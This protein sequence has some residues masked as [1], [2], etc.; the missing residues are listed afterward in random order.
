MQKFCSLRLYVKTKNLSNIKK[1]Y[2]LILF[3]LPSIII[4]LLF[5][6]IPIYGVQIAF[7]DYSFAK[8][9][10]R[11]P[12]VGLRFFKIFFRSYYSG[13]IIKNT[14]ILSG[15]NLLF[16]FPFPI[17]LA[18]F[19]NRLNNQPIKRVI[20]TATYMP[21]FISIV[22]VVGMIRL[23]LSPSLGIYG[24]FMRFIGAEP[25]NLLAEPSLF[26]PIYVISEVWQHM[27]WNSI[28]FLAALSAVDV[29]LYESAQADGANKFQLLWYI[30]L[31]SLMPTVMI[32]LILNVGGLIGLG[33]DKVYLMQNNLNTS[34]SEV[35]STYIYKIGIQQSQYSF[36][37]AVGLT[38]N[39][40]NL[41]LLVSANKL[42][43][44]FGRVSL[45]QLRQK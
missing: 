32:L 37:A 2:E 45:S 31:P 19:L 30:D 44:T 9:I 15:L 10:T 17:I 43:K 4:L 22:A 42:A 25:L 18:L 21:H 6:Y 12:W 8:G 33:F 41:I 27:G 20:Q 26:R 39:I 1:N 16:T 3:V 11:S 13:L 5:H 36:T 38:I 23:F 29:E 14:L 28:I 40:V 24:H 34:V 7:R 35:I